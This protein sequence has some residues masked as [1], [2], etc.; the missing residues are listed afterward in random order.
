MSLDLIVG[1]KFPVV[2]WF[3]LCVDYLTGQ[4]VYQFRSLLIAKGEG[5]Q[6][7]TNDPEIPDGKFWQIVVRGCPVH[8][9]MFISI[10]TPTSWWNWLKWKGLF[11]D[12]NNWGV[13][14][15]AVI[16]SL[17]CVWLFATPWTVACQ[18]PLSSTVSLSLL[19]FMSIELVVQSNHLILCCSLLLLPSIFPSIRVF[20]NESV[21]CIRWSKYWRFN[22]GI[23][24][25]NECSGL[26]FQDY[27][28]TH[29]SSPL[30]SSPPLLPLISAF[31]HLGTILTWVLHI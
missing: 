1:L 20:S 21:L 12:L 10:Y 28:K 6:K 25:S 29:T 24:P 4:G 14:D 9:R 26:I 7:L 13:Q 31:F 23:S 17:S 8:C 11:T 27:S 3:R 18:A 22:F 15:C 16:Q 30:P 5:S 2:L 19:K